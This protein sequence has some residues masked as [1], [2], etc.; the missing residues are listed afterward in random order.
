MSQQ[1]NN[2]KSNEKLRLKSKDFWNESPMDY[3]GG[4]LDRNFK[5]DEEYKAYFDK[6]DSEFKRK[7]ELYSPDWINDEPFSN[8]VDFNSMEGKRVLEIG[9]GLGF[10]TEQ[11][12][13]HGANIVSI[14]QTVTAAR[15]TQKRLSLKNLSGTPVIANAEQLPFKMKSFD[16]VWSWGVIDHTPRTDVVV[17]EIDRVLDINGKTK[18]MV[19]HR[20]SLF[21]WYNIMF[22]NGIL[23]GKLLKMSPQELR[24]YCSDNHCPL[25]QYFK[26]KTLREYF[27]KF[28]NVRFNAYE[29]R[30]MFLSHFS[31]LSLF[32]RVNFVERL[33]D[34]LIP[35]KLKRKFLNSYG[36][37]ILI[38]ADKN[39]LSE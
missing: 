22:V 12:S 32:K 16:F 34:F 5:S 2:Y 28:E 13:S 19:Y 33:V 31:W 25:A 11:F 7:H 35:D 17:D 24:S 18:V 20:L 23:K 6:I 15:T 38:T 39:T 36:H 3:F 21:H 27:N 29:S 9:C 37:M 14:D 30:E 8:I 1:Q 4:G 10:N 26:K